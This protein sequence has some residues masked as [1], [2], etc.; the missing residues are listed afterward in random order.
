MRIVILNNVPDG[1]SYL[2]SPQV[3]ILDSSLSFQSHINICVFPSTSTSN[4]SA[5]SSKSLH[6]LQLVQTSAR[7]IT[8]PS[9][10]HHT[11]YKILLDTVKVINN[12]APHYVRSSP[13]HLPQPAP[14]DAP[15]PSTLPVLAPRGA[16]LSF[17]CFLSVIRLLYYI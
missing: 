6:K 16:E 11:T 8:R 5:P 10:F 14:L 7:I 4:V 3:V 2:L 17:H 15:P 12:L 1:P 9:S 13:H